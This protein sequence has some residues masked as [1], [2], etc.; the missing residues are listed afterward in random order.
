MKPGT[1]RASCAPTSAGLAGVEERLRFVAAVGVSG[2]R[3]MRY[4]TTLLL[5]GLLLGC[6]KGGSDKANPRLQ[7]A[8]DKLAA[9][10]SPELRFCALGAAAKQ[11]FAAGKVEDARKYAQELMAL[12]PSFRQ[13]QEYGNA[14]HDANLTLGRIAVREGR[15]DEAK[16]H[17]IESIRTPG[18]RLMDY[19]PNMSLAKDLLEKG[20]RQVVLDYFA[21]CKKFW[22][23][24]RLDEWSQQVKEG[25]TPD[26]G[27]NLVN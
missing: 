21:L 2:N 12:L 13:N 4:I 1:R 9:A 20:E 17:L 5:C 10:N 6:G 7:P 18:G 3:S 15:L 27:A 8:L 16:R 11:S 25:K 14:V 26:F 24:G 23:F 22:N 19:G